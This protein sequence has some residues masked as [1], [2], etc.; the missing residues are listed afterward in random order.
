MTGIIGSRVCGGKGKVK[1]KVKV[2]EI[3]GMIPH[4]TTIA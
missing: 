2:K 3:K 1:V 4:T